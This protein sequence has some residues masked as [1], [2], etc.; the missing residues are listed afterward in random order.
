[1]S[2]KQKLLICI[3]KSN[4]GGAQKYVYDVAVAAKNNNYDVVVLLGGEGE[5]KQKLLHQNIGTITL[6]NSRRDINITREFG[7]LFELIKIFRHEKPDIVHL[8]SSKIGFIGALAGRITGIKKVI[9]TV[10]GWAFNENRNIFQRYIFR[11]LQILNLALAHRVIVVSQSLRNQVS[12]FS[13]KI[14]VINNGIENINFKNREG[15]RADL[16]SKIKDKIVVPENCIWIGT[17]SE[18]HKNK[19]LEYALDA[20]SEINKEFIF[21]VIGEGEERK[22]L[23]KKVAKHGLEKKIFFIGH[24]ENASSYLKAFD[25]FT[26]TS[27]TESF[28]FVILEAGLAEIPV[29]ASSVGGIPEIIENNVDGLLVGVKEPRKIKEAIESLIENSHLRKV[30]GEKLGEKVRTKFTVQEMLL[31]T[32]EA[33]KKND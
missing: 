24:L 21:F 33:Y 15:A 5:L 18:L 17:I 14:I 31:K 22:V 6:K 26:L 19:G 16:L 25:I 29:V 27:I 10:H 2:K 8:N 4:W 1:M 20:L 12:S 3:T 30:L 23:E 7:L 11:F 28:G 13:K 9:F 32:F